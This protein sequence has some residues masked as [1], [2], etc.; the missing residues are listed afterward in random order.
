MREWI[1]ERPDE[2]VHDEKHDAYCKGELIRCKDCEYWVS[3]MK[4]CTKHPSTVH[5]KENDYC[6]FGERND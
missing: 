6:S 1:F 5:W 2:F 4:G 3:H